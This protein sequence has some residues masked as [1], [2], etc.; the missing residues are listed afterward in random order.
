MG[1]IGIPKNNLISTILKIFA[2]KLFISNNNPIVVLNTCYT[3]VNSLLFHMA[4]CIV[5]CE[6]VC[7]NCISAIKIGQ[8]NVWWIQSEI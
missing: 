1:C 8:N 4:M 7:D 5:Q 2:L 3:F 6:F